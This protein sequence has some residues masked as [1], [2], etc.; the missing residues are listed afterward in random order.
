MLSAGSV[1]LGLH[2][3]LVQKLSDVAVATCVI[4]SVQGVSYRQLGT[5]SVDVMVALAVCGAAKSGAV[6]RQGMDACLFLNMKRCASNCATMS[7]CG[8]PVCLSVSVLAAVVKRCRHRRKSRS[9]PYDGFDALRSY[10][11]ITLECVPM[12]VC[13]DEDGASSSSNTSNDAMLASG[14]AASTLIQ[15]LMPILLM[16]GGRQDVPP[17]PRDRYTVYYVTLVPSD[18]A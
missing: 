10:V 12:L 3:D 13:A 6:A 15:S 5:A 16:Q 1:P 18:T 9:S 14:G 11:C 8:V 7:I 17:Q 4:A 2:H